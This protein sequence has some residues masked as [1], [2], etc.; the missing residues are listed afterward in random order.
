MANSEAADSRTA[1]VRARGLGVN[2]IAGRG[3]EDLK[4]FFLG[5]LGKAEIFWAL[6]EIDFSAVP[7]DIVGI[8]GANG[9]GKTT[10]CSV[11]SLFAAL[12]PACCAPMKAKR[13]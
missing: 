5:N 2:Y 12:S 10:L 7:G 6:R 8:I 11:I 9:A 1:Y 4:S 3:R 13:M